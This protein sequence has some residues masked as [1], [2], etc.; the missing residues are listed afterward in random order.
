MGNAPKKTDYG[1]G[2]SSEGTG[3]GTN[4][5]NPDD[6]PFKPTVLDADGNPIDLDELDAEDSED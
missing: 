5:V 1:S 3:I 6:P 4:V 2:M